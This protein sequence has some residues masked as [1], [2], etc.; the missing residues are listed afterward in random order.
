MAPLQ[1][2]WVFFLAPFFSRLA[3]TSWDTIPNAWARVL[4][5]KKKR[6]LSE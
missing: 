2:R 5:L 1:T 6:V 3:K 4:K